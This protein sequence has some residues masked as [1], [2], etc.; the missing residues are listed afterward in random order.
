MLQA[1]V[2]EGC[3]A[4]IILLTGKGDRGNRY[5]GDEGRSSRLSM[6]NSVERPFT[7]TFHS[8][9]PRTPAHSS[10]KFA[11]KPN[12]SMSPPMPLLLD[13]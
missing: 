10:N 5:R 12:Y 8:L 4:P 11:P 6:K 2:A 9:R 7:R 1:A 13:R 3:A